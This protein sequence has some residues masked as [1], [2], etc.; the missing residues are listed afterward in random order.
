[1]NNC[2][3]NDCSTFGLKK[4]L[5]Q[6]RLRQFFN[7]LYDLFSALKKESFKWQLKFPRIV[8]KSNFM[9]DKF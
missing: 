9:P 5:D 2:N 4:F 6:A 7:N 1:M 3:I 8:G